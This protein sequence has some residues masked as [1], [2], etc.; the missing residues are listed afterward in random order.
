MNL[1][2]IIIGGHI[3]AGKSTIARYL[4]KK[5]KYHKYSLGDG[6]KNFVVDLYKI[7]HTLHPEINEIELYE[8]Y[9]RET[10]ENHRQKMQL[11][12]T[13]LIRNYFGDDI[14][15]KYLINNIKFPFVIDDLRFKN[16]YQHFKNMINVVY[17]RVVRSEELLSN[18]IS[19]Q[20][21]K[22][23]KPDYIIIND[24]NI[25][26]LYANIEKMID[27]IIY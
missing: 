19:E 16:E 7:L 10:K 25:N 2:N 26:E 27:S 17:V 24:G 14:W 4:E 11:L 23:I 21:L 1:P 12:S 6:V 18:H 8:L 9:N 5:Y 3:N 22:D 13:E 15:I 20:D